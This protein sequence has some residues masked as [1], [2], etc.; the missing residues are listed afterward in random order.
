[1]IDEAVLDAGPVIHLE[2]IESLELLDFIGKM[3]V[4]GEVA[5]EIGKGITEQINVV[6][7]PLEGEA[8]D[9]AKYLSNKYNIELGEATAISLCQQKG[10]KILFTDD[11]NAR[12]VAERVGLEPHGT[13]AI[14]TRAYSEGII[15]EEKA[16]TVIEQLR[17][18]SRLFLTSDLVRW[19][20]ERIEKH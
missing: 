12:K 8:K 20:K 18:D 1:M 17:K 14:V 15:E 2:Q 7:K 6:E 10:V 13:L 3:Y 4:S 19:A 16:K 5:D 9:N 11:L